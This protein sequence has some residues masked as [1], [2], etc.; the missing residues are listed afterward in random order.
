MQRSIS[1]SQQI[2]AR[3][4]AAYQAGNIAQAEFLYKL[5]LQADKKQFDALHMLGLIEA[6]RGNFAAGLIRIKD[7][8][9]ARPNAPE[10]L[11]NLGRIQNELGDRAA[12]VATYKKALKADPKSALG[13]SNLSILLRK[14]GQN[15]EALVHCDAA[16][17]IVPDYADAWSNR[18]NVLFDLKRYGEA[19]E[20]YD[21]ALALQPALGEAHLGRGNVL[22]RLQRYDEALTAYD[23]A[24]AVQPNDVGVWLGRGSVLYYL[25]RMPESLVAYDRAIAIKPDDAD[26]WLRRGQTLARLPRDQEAYE[27]YARAFAIDPSLP[28]AEGTRLSAKMTICDWSDLDAERAHLVAEIRQ[29]ALRSDPFR[30]FAISTSAADQMKCAELYLADRYPAASQPLWRG[31]R[32]GHDRIRIGYL[33]PDLRHHAVAYLTAGMFE[34]HDRSR[35]ETI[36][37]SFGPA[38]GDMQARL[39]GAFDRFIDVRSRT[40]QD[41][42]QL[43]RDLE[44][45]I[46]VDLSGITENSRP[47]V[48]AQRGA[49]IQVNYLGYA[50]TMPARYIDYILADPTVIPPEHA[51]YYGES[52]AWLP[53]TFMATDDKRRIAE[54]TPTR[55]ECGLPQEA[56][57]FCCFNNAYKMTPEVFNIWMTL[58]REVD[59][60]V[61]WLSN[62]NATAQGNLRRE[63]ESRGVSA[64]RL[65]FAQRAPDV[66][67]HLA[68]QRCADLFIDTSPYNAHTT[69]NDALWGGL[70]VLTCLGSTF[71]SRVAASLVRAI[72]LPEMAVDSWLEYERLAL[73]LARDPELL[74][75]IKGKLAR[76]RNSFPLFDTARFTRNV[77]AAFTAMWERHLRGEAP[78]NFAV[79]PQ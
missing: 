76:N 67:D 50:G 43:I 68:R 75:A 15:D 11:I 48:L 17:K 42:A 71:P 51:A 53:D 63:A 29:G 40:D 36:A 56:F 74:G 62:L 45:D 12:A 37:I 58:L 22:A 18:G 13:H 70:P 6:Q 10:A 38:G 47:A 14:G 52:I 64:Q 44:I 27:A 25:L 69:A 1:Q 9:R 65:I 23:R 31:E 5:V 4:V 55:E 79:D 73:Q 35:F 24:L 54:H 39:R 34:A 77:E 61:L 20:S 57:V 7:A 26:A 3:A 8:L 60:S 72:G 32:Y 49:P 41:I 2:L 46:L 30:F 21:R 66:A 16:L 33:S 78:Q 59:G 19:L 28:Y